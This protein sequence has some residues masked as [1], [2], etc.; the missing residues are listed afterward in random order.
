MPIYE[1][2]CQGCGQVFEHLA[3]RQGDEG[4]ASCPA[5]GGE[6]LA[7]VM[8]ACSSVVEG[9]PGG[10]AQPAG[11]VEKRSCGDSGSCS[12]ITLPGHSR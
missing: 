8:S 7:R 11:G 10:S 2:R 4:Q 9:S 5:C 3:L 6:E 12:T 1:F